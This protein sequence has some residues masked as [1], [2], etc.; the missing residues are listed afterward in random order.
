MKTIEL[1]QGYYALVDDVDYEYLN[2][3][4]WHT[5]VR[6]TNK[7]ARRVSRNKYIYMHRVIAERMGLN[8]TDLRIG[9]DD[10]NGLN[11]SRS[12]IIAARKI[13]LLR[14]VIRGSA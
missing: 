10:G 6:G 5:V 3:F 8:I 2:Q 14:K 11:N 12:N 9:H 7:Y 13:H 1:T 4:N